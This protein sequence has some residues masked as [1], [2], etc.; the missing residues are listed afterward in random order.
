MDPLDVAI[1]ALRLALVLVLYLFL[2]TVV[3]LS[4]RSLNAAAP[5]S[6]PTSAPSRPDA[7]PATSLRLLVLEA[8]DSGLAPGRVL[9]VPA[10]A[11]LGRAERADVVLADPTVSGEHARL[12]RQRDRWLVED[13]GST[14]GT[15]LN[16][17]PVHGPVPLAGG[18]EVALGGVRL[19]VVGP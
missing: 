2:V 14:N 1:L 5:A 7:R 6:A 15:L 16:R 3:R 11:T 9:D 13:L 10:G 18:D 17:Q 19:R 12:S 8:G 4:S